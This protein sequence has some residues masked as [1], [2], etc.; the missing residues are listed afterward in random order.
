VAVTGRGE[1]ASP[2]D[3]QRDGV[4]HGATAACVARD[5]DVAA[6]WQRRRE[7]AA[8]AMQLSRACDASVRVPFKWRLRLTSG[9]RQFFY[10]RRF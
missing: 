1:T 3:R 5:A 6:G 7:V 2:T 10:L 8:M 4:T 9:P